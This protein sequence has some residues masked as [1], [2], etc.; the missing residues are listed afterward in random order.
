M[1]LMWHTLPLSLILVE[2]DSIA[3]LGETPSQ[4]VTYLP[5]SVCP[6][7]SRSPGAISADNDTFKAAGFAYTT[8]TAEFLDDIPDDHTFGTGEESAGA[9][10]LSGVDMRIVAADLGPMGAGDH[11]IQVNYNGIAIGSVGRKFWFWD[12]A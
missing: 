5:L 2:L 3:I 7:A 9:N 6:G 11:F 4:P 1:G 12:E 8:T 10:L